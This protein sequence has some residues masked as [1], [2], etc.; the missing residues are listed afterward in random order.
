[1]TITSSLLEVRPSFKSPQI[2]DLTFL[3]YH[4][5]YHFAPQ[6]FCTFFMYFSFQTPTFYFLVLRS[7]FQFSAF[8]FAYHLHILYYLPT[9]RHVE[10]T[11][12]QRVLSSFLFFSGSCSIESLLCPRLSGHLH[13]QYIYIV[14]IKSYQINRAI[15][16]LV[17]TL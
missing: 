12:L 9:S 3:V 15:P 14:D 6:I 2:N 8:F 10:G 5:Y 7:A 16:R 13:W 17:E 11:F 4:F 1:M